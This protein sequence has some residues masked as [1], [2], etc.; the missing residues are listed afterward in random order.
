ME[1]TESKNRFLEKRNKNHNNQKLKFFVQQIVIDS[2][3]AQG[4]C[5]YG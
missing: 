4:S 5:S 3:K 1:K 2:Q